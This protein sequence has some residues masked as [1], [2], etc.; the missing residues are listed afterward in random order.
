MEQ[1]QRAGE[2]STHWFDRLFYKLGEQPHLAQQ[3]IEQAIAEKLA[4]KHHLGPVVAGLRTSESQ[5]AWTYIQTWVNSDDPIMWL[6]V[7]DSYRF[8]NWSDL[9]TREWEVL[10]HLVAKGSS[11][12]DGAILWLLRQFAPY[13]SDLAVELL[14]TMANRGDENI[15]RHIAQVLSVRKSR[16]GWLVEFAHSQ[17]YLEIIQNFERLPW[18]DSETEECLNRLGQVAPKQVVDF[19]ERRINTK[20]QRRAEDVHYRVFPLS[21]SLA[22]SSIQ[23]SP[24]YSDVLRRVRDWMLREDGWFYF[25]TPHVLKA[26]AVNLEGPLYTVLMEWINSGD[27][28]KQK[29]VARILQEF[30]AGQAFYHMSR[31]LLLQTRVKDKVILS[32]LQTAIYSAPGATFGPFSNHTQQRLEEISHWLQDENLQVRHF[33]NQIVTLLQEDLERQL[34]HEDFEKRTW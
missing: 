6:A 1:S 33:A 26:I 12:V 22:T 5:V 3:L 24:E 25:E 19:I 4:L 30:N 32:D 13:N 34:A 17:D 29:A 7:E 10:R 31:E 8:V 23:C 2:S 9:D 11:L 28:H 16:E 15:L 14:K 18:L 27:I 20:T 21:S